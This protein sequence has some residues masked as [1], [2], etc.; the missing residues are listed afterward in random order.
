MSELVDP[1]NGPEWLVVR[2]LPAGQGPGF[3]AG[4]YVVRS[5]PCHWG[6]RVTLPYPTRERAERVRRILLGEIT[7]PSWLRHVWPRSPEPA[8]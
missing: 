6:E 7:T 5:C 1:H 4:W 3:L 8:A 2:H